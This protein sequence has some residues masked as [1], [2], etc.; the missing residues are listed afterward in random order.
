M[1]ESD[2]ASCRWYK[3][4]RSDVMSQHADDVGISFTLLE[5]AA[6]L[7]QSV[8]LFECFLNICVTP[9]IIIHLF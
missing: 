4:S 8:T 1:R 3:D 6:F 5:T 2:R 7:H 9:K